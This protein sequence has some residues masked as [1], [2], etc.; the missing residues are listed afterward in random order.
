MQISR[1]K[2]QSDSEILKDLTNLENDVY[3]HS[4]EVVKNSIFGSDS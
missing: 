4:D 1:L 3:W 2:L